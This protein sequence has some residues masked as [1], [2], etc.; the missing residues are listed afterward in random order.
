MFDR[1]TASAVL[2]LLS[3]ALALPS[4]AA[5]TDPISTSSN[6][7][8]TRFDSGELNLTDDGYV[9]DLPAPPAGAIGYKV[10][11]EIEHGYSLTFENRSDGPLAY[12]EVGGR[13]VLTV[14]G[15]YLVRCYGAAPSNVAASDGQNW[16]GADCRRVDFDSGGF[17]PM[18]MTYAAPIEAWDGRL[19]LFPHPDG[20]EGWMDSGYH[21]HAADYHVV[22]YQAGPITA[23]IRGCIV[24]LY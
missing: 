24:W 20:V 4:R 21:W 22:P 17:V 12:V 1:L 8:V 5:S 9:V 11:A 14:G 23:R 10:A 13:F 18:G 16:S 7:T 19:S 6:A 2:A 15:S 3:A